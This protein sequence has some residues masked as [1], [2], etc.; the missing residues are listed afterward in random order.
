MKNKFKA[1]DK[2]EKV[3]HEAGFLMDRIAKLLPVIFILHM[4]PL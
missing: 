1:W 2:K 4:H 3:M